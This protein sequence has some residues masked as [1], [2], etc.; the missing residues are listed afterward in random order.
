M[1]RAASLAETCFLKSRTPVLLQPLSD[2]LL[3]A[4]GQH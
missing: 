2:A 3:L 4:F 1:I